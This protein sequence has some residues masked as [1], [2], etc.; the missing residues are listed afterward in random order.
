MGRSKR[1]R[2]PSARQPGAGYRD[3]RQDPW[4]G[5]PEYLGE[6]VDPRV[7]DGESVLTPEEVAEFL[8]VRVQLLAK[9]RSAGKGPNS[10]K[11]GRYVRY[12]R[13]ELLDWVAARASERAGGRH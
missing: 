8:Q 1:N 9:W 5:D 7:L 2:P 3:D 10:F 6:L 4:S 12:S 13:I 11:I